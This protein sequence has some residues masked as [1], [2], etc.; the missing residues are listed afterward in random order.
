LLSWGIDGRLCLW[1]SYG[2][3]HLSPLAILVDKEDYPI[4]AVDLSA[5]ISK[6]GTK[7]DKKRLVVGGG[8]E[9]GFIGIAAYLYDISWSDTQNQS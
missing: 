4:Y 9:G 5:T 6:K 7:E 2:K 3:G 1:N 8:A